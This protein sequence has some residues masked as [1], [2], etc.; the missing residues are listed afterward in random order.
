MS[1]K[2]AAPTI[3]WVISSKIT[4]WLAWCFVLSL[5]VIFISLW[6]VR[7]SINRDCRDYY[8]RDINVFGYWITIQ[9]GSSKTGCP[10]LTS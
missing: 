2:D 3:G 8:T 9:A 7:Y 10:N 1:K 5:L 6:T 4:R